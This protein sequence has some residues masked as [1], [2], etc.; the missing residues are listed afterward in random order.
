VAVAVVGVAA[1]TIVVSFSYV[2]VQTKSAC[3]VV[4]G[5]KVAVGKAASVLAAA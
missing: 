1:V 3:I 2:A 5:V 4:G